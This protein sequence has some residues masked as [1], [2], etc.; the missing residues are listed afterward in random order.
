MSYT[1]LLYRCEQDRL[2]RLDR[3]LH[4][5]RVESVY[6][7]DSAEQELAQ[8]QPDGMI[9]PITSETLNLYKYVKESWESPTRPVLVLITEKPKRGLPADL[10]L[11]ARWLDHALHSELKR[12]SENI[13]LQ[14]KLERRIGTVAND[15]DVQKRALQEVDLLRTTIVRNISHELKTPLLHVKSAV[16]MLSEDHDR[17]R[18]TLIGYATEATAR[19]EVVVKNVTQLADAL[20]IEL[21]PTHVL[22]AVDQAARNLRRIW[23]QQENLDRVK[24]NMPRSLPLVWA[25]KPAISIALQHLI[26]NGLKFSKKPVEVSARVQDRHVVITVKDRGIGIPEDK[27]NAIFDPFYQIENTDARRYGGLGVGLAIVRLILDRH[28]A[29][30]TVESAVGKGSTFS[31]DSALCRMT[32]LTRPSD[33]IR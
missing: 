2:K 5:Y 19:L 6:D 16:A 21:E 25:D 23:E 33:R 11:P 8:L 30:I 20:D 31:F 13:Q 7:S 22:D 9:A 14:Q 32:F 4:P 24:L 1:L 17:D 15:A 27:L 26:D 3:R 18:G 12:R 28:D 29:R 10:V